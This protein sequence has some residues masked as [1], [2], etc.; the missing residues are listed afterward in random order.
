[1]DYLSAKE[2]ASGNVQKIEQ[3][4][5]KIQEWLSKDPGHQQELDQA[6]WLWENTATLPEN[7]EWKESFNTIQASLLQDASRKTIRLKFWLAAA[8]AIAA[9]TL[10]TLFYKVKHPV[11]QQT[12]IAWITKSASSGK[13]SKVMLP[14]S[15]QIWL[16]SGSSISYPKKPPAC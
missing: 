11:L 13:M 2:N 12:S 7:D 14:D 3:E 10:F 15:S 5:Q 6:L 1:M 4:E 16:N 8:A 9:I